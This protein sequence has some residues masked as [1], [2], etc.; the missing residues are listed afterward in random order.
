MTLDTI[1]A[2]IEANISETGEELVTVTIEGLVGYYDDDKGKTIEFIQDW[3]V[4]NVEGDRININD[5]DHPHLCSKFQSWLMDNNYSDTIDDALNY[6][7]GE[8]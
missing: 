8:R 1:N 6:E 5:Y 3:W 2:T 7:L 4:C